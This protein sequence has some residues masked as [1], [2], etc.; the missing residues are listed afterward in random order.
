MTRS[1]YY[2]FF[3]TFRTIQ[4]TPN[5]N[6]DSSCLYSSDTRRV[7]RG[8]VNGKTAFEQN[9]P[10]TNVGRRRTSQ[11]MWGESVAN[12]LIDPFLIFLCRNMRW[13]IYMRERHFFLW[14]FSF[15]KASCDSGIPSFIHGYL[16][17]LQPNML[18][19][20][21]YYEIYINVLNSVNCWTMDNLF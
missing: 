12:Q 6:V 11:T 19:C 9:Q 14:V 16:S 8:A 17:A 7:L 3:F 1:Y 21:R 18:I 15:D 5:E 13:N 4:H 10:N 20:A 2:Y